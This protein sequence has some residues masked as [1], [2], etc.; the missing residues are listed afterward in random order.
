MGDD[1]GLRRSNPV[2]G[3][4]QPKAA[5][6]RD[7]V[8]TDDELI[9]IWTACQDDDY[10]KIIR[11]LVLTG[12]RRTEIGGLRWSEIDTE[13]GTWTIPAA[14]SK[15]G[16]AHTPA[17]D[18]DG[19]RDH[20][21]WCRAWPPRSPVRLASGAGFSAFADGKAALDERLVLPLGACMT[22]G[23]R[24][25]L[26]WPTRAW[27]RMWSS[28]SSTINPAIGAVRLES[29]IEAFIERSPRG[30][31]VV[32]RSRPY[33]GRGRRAQGGSVARLAPVAKQHGGKRAWPGPA[34]VLSGI[35]EIAVGA[36]YDRLLRQLQEA[37]AWE[38]HY[39]VAKHLDA[40]L[41]IAKLQEKFRGLA[42][43]LP[44]RH[45]ETIRKKLQK[46]IRKKI[47]AIG[48]R[49][50]VQLK[51]P[52]N[53]R[54]IVTAQVIAWCKKKYGVEIKPRRVADCRAKH[55]RLLERLHKDLP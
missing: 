47:D 52:K 2:I 3:T 54:A 33:A 8:L 32:G 13:A 5:E 41:E 29:T 10:G 15:N 12:C 9:R 35:R 38:K 4:A 6:P 14:R 28:R 37:K 21:Q 53:A 26:S 20:R 48:R 18:A 55:R 11:L 16:R 31:G 43:L 19:A 39:A 50:S 36:E 46:E 22:S 34:P 24:S 27:R 40:E 1:H 7:R 44:H 49:D 17:A 42:K 23:A 25:P 51:R 45:Q 30:V